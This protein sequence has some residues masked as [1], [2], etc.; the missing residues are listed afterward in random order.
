MKKKKK[1]INKDKKYKLINMHGRLQLS[2]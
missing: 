1:H 2:S